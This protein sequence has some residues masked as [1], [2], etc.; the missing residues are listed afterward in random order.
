MCFGGFLKQY[1][2]AKF[3]I[4]AKCTLDVGRRTPNLTFINSYRTSLCLKLIVSESSLTG[5]TSIYWRNYIRGVGV[6]FE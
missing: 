2:T 6:I 4:N 5:A 3:F 1:M